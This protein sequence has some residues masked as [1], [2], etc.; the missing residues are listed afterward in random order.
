MSDQKIV[1]TKYFADDEMTEQLAEASVRETAAWEPGEKLRVVGTK[2]PRIDGYDK[3]SGTAQYTFDVSLPQMAHGRVLRCP[4]PHARIRSIDLSRAWKIRGV[5]DIITH[6]NSEPITWRGDTSFLFDPHLR[7]E[8]DE[9]A[10][11]AA[12][13]AAI[14]ERAAKAIGV[15]YEVLAFVTDPA[16]AM[17]EG[18]PKIHDYGNIV[19]DRSRPYSRG[20]V[21]QGFADADVI[22]EG[23]FSTRVAVHNPT[24]PHGSVANWDGDRLTV[25]DSTQAIYSVRDTI[26]EKLK[27]PASHVQVIKKFMGGGFGS[28]LSCGKHS[29]MAAILARRAGRPVKITMDR[30]EMNLAM[31]NRPDSVQRLKIGAGRDGKLLAMQMYSHG[32]VG[33]Y[34][35]GAGCSWPLKTLYQCDNCSVEEYSV[36]GN[37]GPACAMRA[38][39]HVPGTFALESLMDDLA[40]KLGLDPVELRILNHTDRD[41]VMGLPYTSKR[42]IEAY[43]R[44]AEAIGWDRRNRVPGDV[45]GPVKRGL[46]MA[47]QIW[48]GGGTPPSGCILKLNRDGSARVLAGTQDI[49]TGTSTF[50]AM[51]VAEVLGIPLDRISV[52]VGD[53]A[54]GPYCVLSGGSL[55]A[56]SVSPAVKEAAELMKAKLISGAAAILELPENDLSLAAGA[57]VS[58]TDGSKSVE[59]PSIF[60]QLREQTLVT[61]GARNANPEGYAINTFGA[62]FAEVEVDTETGR[63]RVRKVV[64]AHDV[65]LMLNHMTLENQMHG[66]VIQGVG[67]ALFEQQVVDRNS[68]LVLNANLHGY[69]VPT[70]MDM[71]EIEVIVVSDA[72]PKISNTG[73]KGCGE[74]AHIPTAGA[75]A[76]AVYNA[77]GVRV[78]DLPM[79]P[80]RV[81]E[82]LARTAHS[83]SAARPDT[84]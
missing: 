69:K 62:Q 43:R 27:I 11:V 79:T 83:P 33:A 80:A 21:E 35:Y 24:E 64:A 18:A 25:W 32:S 12:E 76:N 57:V 1:K 66:G 26:A 17:E 8:G 47:S 49:G 37:T 38:P 74:P 45:A 20:D 60:E 84:Q 78:K 23:D 56:P 44:G 63:V 3:V 70:M 71:P 13:T 75:I 73:V 59:I 50:M 82:A 52:T 41:Q 55:T 58:R 2:V 48:W 19:E 68:G 10:C 51:I 4:H 36:H 5:L 81:L 77:I 42:L 54:A 14:A 6:E 28:K 46:G 72:D 31:G 61:T 67:Y 30:R 39:G 29:V 22:V 7:H 65:G 15:D 16:K 40:E 34:P 9:V 53:T